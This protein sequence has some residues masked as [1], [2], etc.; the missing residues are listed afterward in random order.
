[1]RSPEIRKR[2]KRGLKMNFNGRSSRITE[3]WKSSSVGD[4]RNLSKWFI[5]KGLSHIILK[6]LFRL[7]LKYE[8]V[9]WG[10]LYFANQILVKSNLKVGHI[11]F[12]SYYIILY[13]C[14]AAYKWATYISWYHNILIKQYLAILKI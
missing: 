9:L 12:S 13:L 8:K 6:M 4:L 7:P 14:L 5:R 2:L 10:T 3:I 1:M 11:L